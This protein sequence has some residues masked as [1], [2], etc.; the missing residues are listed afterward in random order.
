MLERKSSIGVLVRFS[1]KA[2]S[3]ITQNLNSLL[4]HTQRS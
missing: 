2:N 1:S 4:I 3:L